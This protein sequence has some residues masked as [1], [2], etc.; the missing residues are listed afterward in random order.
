MTDYP[1]E[2]EIIESMLQEAPINERINSDPL[3]MSAQELV[4]AIQLFL[5]EYIQVEDYT[6]HLLDVLVKSDT[7][8]ERLEIDLEMYKE[9]YQRVMP[10]YSK[11]VQYIQYLED[12][13]YQIPNFLKV[14][15]GIPTG[16]PFIHFEYKEDEYVDSSTRSDAP[17]DRDIYGEG[18]EF[19]TAEESNTCG[20]GSPEADATVMCGFEPPVHGTTERTE[21]ADWKDPG[22]S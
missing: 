8:I 13:V 4:V 5:S 2:D 17:D 20:C 18:S 11:Q 15:F 1:S 10:Q 19:D 12:L 21:E 6:V 9:G 22:F 16:D 7:K 3:M 14:L